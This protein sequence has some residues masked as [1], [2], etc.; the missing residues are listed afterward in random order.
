MIETT[1]P[2]SERDEWR[3]PPAVFEWFHERLRFAWDLAS[4]SENTLCQGGGITRHDDA[5]ALS[6]ASVLSP[7]RGW[8]NP[9]YSDIDPW[10]EKAVAEARRGFTSAFLIPSPNGEERYHRYVFGAASEVHFIG[11]RLAFLRPDGTPQAGNR[12]GSIVVVYRGFDLG[13]TRYVSVTRDEMQA[14]YDA[15]RERAA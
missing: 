4:T 10:L 2:A 5:L 13:N 6:W 12:W 8:C 7:M 15:R 11:G 9:P 3:T 1:T 14:V